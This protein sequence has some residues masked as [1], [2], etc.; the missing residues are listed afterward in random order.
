MRTILATYLGAIDKNQDHYLKGVAIIHDGLCVD[1]TCSMKNGRTL[2]FE[3][4][5]DINV[6]RFVDT[7]VQFKW[8][9][10]IDEI[11]F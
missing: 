10:M 2:F 8:L 11:P 9:H 4:N 7:V 6:D 1:S 3:F 5:S